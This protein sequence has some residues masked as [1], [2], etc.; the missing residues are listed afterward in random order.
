[1]ILNKNI[2]CN[3]IIVI[4]VTIFSFIIMNSRI[5]A[6]IDEPSRSLAHLAKFVGKYPSF[7]VDKTSDKI[8]KGKSLTDD[9]AFRQYLMKALGK[10]RFKIFMDGLDVET[11]I[12][13]KGQVLYFF[14]AKPHYAN[15]NNATTFINLSDNSVEIYWHDANSPNNLWLSSKKPPRMIPKNEDREGL[16]LYEKYGGH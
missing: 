1:M 13:Q 14:K 16:A 8:I 9:Q 3:L 15:T 5:Y 4:L 7:E 10:D 2:K 12:E 6:H 11:P